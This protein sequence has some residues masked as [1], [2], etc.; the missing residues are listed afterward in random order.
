MEENRVSLNNIIRYFSPAWYAAVMGTGGLANVMFALSEKIPMLKSVSVILWLLTAF[1]FILFLGPWLARWFIHFD[2]LKDDL[3]NPMMSN[4]F[5][6]M[7]IG[8]LILGTNFFIIGKE[9]ISMSFT[10]S[11]GM[12]FWAFAVVMALGFGVFVI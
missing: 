11:L 4:F 6:T 5:V 1:L 2:K 12:I 8:G 7:P 10:T 9:Y 3:K